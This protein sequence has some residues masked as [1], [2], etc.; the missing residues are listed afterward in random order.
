[1]IEFQPTVHGRRIRQWENF[2]EYRQWKYF[3][4]LMFRKAKNNN[5]FFNH[6]CISSSLSKSNSVISDLVPMHHSFSPTTHINVDV[7]LQTI[8]LRGICLKSNMLEG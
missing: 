1:M 4:L 5:V 7:I 3:L 8:Y 6:T 2:L